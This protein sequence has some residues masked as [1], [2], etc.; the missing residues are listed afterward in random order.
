MKIVLKRVREA[1]EIGI[2]EALPDEVDE[3]NPDV[4]LRAG[5]ALVR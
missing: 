2:A 5:W 3:R 1:D 4:G